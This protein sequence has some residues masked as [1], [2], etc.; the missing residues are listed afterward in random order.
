[1]AVQMPNTDDAPTHREL[2]ALCE[3]APW[4]EK[5]GRAA[6]RPRI[7]SP[8]WYADRLASLDLDVELWETTYYHRLARPS[9]V[10]EWI[11]G[12]ALRRVSP[13][14]GGAAAEA[15]LAPYPARIE[16]LSRAGPPGVLLPSPRLFFVAAR[17][18]K[19]ADSRVGRRAAS[20]RRAKVIG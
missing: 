20:R 3:E 19:E 10:V 6:L 5:L 2:A 13:R 15:S 11:K 12:S 17:R 14:L 16:R 9:D 4:R 7:E 18:G 1:L 8:A